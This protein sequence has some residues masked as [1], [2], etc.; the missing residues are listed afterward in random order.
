M[1]DFSATLESYT[2]I[3]DPDLIAVE[4]FIYGAFESDIS[5]AKELKTNLNKLAKAKASGDE[6]EIREAKE[7]V[8]DSIEDVNKAAAE[9]KNA[10]RKAKLKKIAKIGGAIAGTIAATVTIAAVAKK[11]KSNVAERR[12]RN[13]EQ[14]RRFAENNAIL[15][16]QREEMEQAWNDLQKTKVSYQKTHSELEEVNRV[17]KEYTKSDNGENLR[18]AEQVKASL[19]R[20]YDNS[21]RD[22]ETGERIKKT[23]KDLDDLLS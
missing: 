5:C 13:E 3:D 1:K 15:K 21:K 19:K 6:S 9:E 23:Q 17:L 7:D 4:S 20:I 2:I 18:P 11:V 22:E 12:A 14:D 10:E 16:R 8:K